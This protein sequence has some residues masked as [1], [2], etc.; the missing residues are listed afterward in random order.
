MKRLALAVLVTSSSACFAQVYV[1]PEV[2]IPGGGQGSSEFKNHET[3]VAVRT[4]NSQHVAV[5]WNRLENAAGTTPRLIHYATSTDGG[6][7]FSTGALLPLP[8]VNSACNPPTTYSVDPIAA[9]SAYSGKLF[10]GGMTASGAGTRMFVSEIDSTG[11]ALPSIAATEWCHSRDKPWM[12]IG[13]RRVEGGTGEAM[14]IQWNSFTFQPPL[15]YAAQH[16]TRSDDTTAPLGSIWPNVAQAVSSSP[17][18]SSG[19][20]GRACANAVL[21]HPDPQFRGRVFAALGDFGGRPFWTRSDDEGAG[22]T[23][24][25]LTEFLQYRGIDNFLGFFPAGSIR[26]GLRPT[27]FPSVVVSPVDG[28]TVFVTFIG[29]D[30]N[31]PE[32]PDVFVAVSLDGGESFDIGNVYRL[33]D[34]HLLLS[35]E[36]PRLAVQAMPSIAIDKLGGIN[37]IFIH[38]RD[39]AGTPIEVTVRYARFDTVASMAGPASHVQDLT[40]LFPL[41][42]TFQIGLLSNDYQMIAASGC[43]LYAAYART[44][45]AFPLRGSSVYVRRIVIGSC[46]LA[47]ADGDGNISSNDPPVFLA[48]M[49]ANSLQADV[50]MDGAVDVQDS[51]EFFNAYNAAYPPP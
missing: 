4:S 14:Y 46:G 43:V 26:P 33:Y 41:T 1:G 12:A 49:A 9:S 22:G 28:K 27:V 11:V 45:P 8:P 2:P 51:M 42:S 18:P 40:P 10:L 39:Q 13:P 25:D 7:T 17:P 29:I 44:D 37:L 21:S 36:E 31:E 6:V 30:E 48:A 38:H 19:F 20:G 5:A 35:H 15:E 3:V 32:N 50:N 23:W 24:A 34:D 47:D 16:N